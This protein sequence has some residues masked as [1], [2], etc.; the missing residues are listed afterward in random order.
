[1]ATAERKDSIRGEL[2]ALVLISLGGL[3]IH[4]HLHP[5]FGPHGD[6]DAL[7]PLIANLLGILVVPFLLSRRKTWL[8]G[9]LVNGFSVVT[10]VVLMGDI[11]VSGWTALPGP[12][13]FVQDAMLPNIIFAFPKLMIGQR[14]LRHYRP[15]GTGRMFTPL[16]WTRHFIYA[17]LVFTAGRL[18]GG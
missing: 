6:E 13:A 15:E 11:M 1:M 14:I 2:A 17:S 16:W 4:T 7:I 3:L 12:A 9:Y 18:I 5:P 8:A 10:G